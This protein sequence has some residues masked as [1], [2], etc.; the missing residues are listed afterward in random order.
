MIKVSTVPTDVGN[1]PTTY[2]SG[3][4]IPS[5][6]CKKEVKEILFQDVI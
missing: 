6:I 1:K 3:N 2:Q 5:W 4:N